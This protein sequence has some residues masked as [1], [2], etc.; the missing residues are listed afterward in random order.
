MSTLVQTEPTQII[1]V[2]A[3][4][5][6]DKAYA[7]M[8]SVVVCGGTALAA[9]S[10]IPDAWIVTPFAPLAIAGMIIHVAGLNLTYAGLEGW[11]KS[12]KMK[13]SIFNYFG[14]RKS[15]PLMKEDAQG[16]VV[17][18]EYVIGRGR[19]YIRE[20][21]Q[22]EPL[23]IWDSS[24]ATIRTLY[25]LERGA[26]DNTKAIDSLPPF[27]DLP[28]YDIRQVTAENFFVEYGSDNQAWAT[29]DTRAKL[30]EKYEQEIRDL[31]GMSP[32]PQAALKAKQKKLHEI[33]TLS[34]VA[35]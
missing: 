10:G 9:F 2:P 23:D 8:A 29:S 19:A 20:T 14:K 12:E 26:T 33:E 31:Q 3:L 1:P 32:C 16:R 11:T 15:Y 25:N 6:S 5:G 27:E 22:F 35:S 13:T 34:K 4:T 28:E 30:I 18:G 7:T 17:K 24:M 21:V